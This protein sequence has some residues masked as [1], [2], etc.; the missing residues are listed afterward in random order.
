VLAVIGDSGNAASI[1]LHTRCGFRP[2]GTFEKVGFKFGRDLDVVLM[3]A[4]LSP[5]ADDLDA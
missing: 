4:S 2:V 3:Q 1:G 5:A